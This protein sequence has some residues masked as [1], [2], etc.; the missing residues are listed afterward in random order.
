MSTDTN[1]QDGAPTADGAGEGKVEAPEIK[2]SKAEYDELVGIKSSYGSLR[3]EFKDLK[4]SLETKES[5]PTPSSKP[6]EEF[7]L[8]QETYLRTT[9]KLET[10]E[11][12][13]LAKKIQ[14]E[15]QMPWDRLVRS[16]YFTAE[17][18]GLRTTKANASAT[19]VTGGQGGSSGKGADYWIAK[20]TPPTAKDIPNRKDRVAVIMAMA[21]NEKNGGGKFYNE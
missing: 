12:I 14:K 10:D 9:A 5:E 20:G 15:T 7:G 8:L 13:E 2:L 16:K 21:D 1:N 18:D 6:T 19:D 3:R 17:L 11:E 4:K